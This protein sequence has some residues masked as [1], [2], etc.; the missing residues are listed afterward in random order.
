[1][2]TLILDG[3]A[4]RDAR[5]TE[6][7]ARIQALIKPPILA[8]V[9]VG[10]REDTNAYIKA[11]ITFGEKLGVVVK[12]IKLDEK[13]SQHELVAKVRECNEDENIKG[14]IIQLPLPIAIDQDAAIEAILPAKDV[15][16][17]TAFNVKQWLEGREE[18][19]L[20]A[21]TRGVKELLEHYKIELFGKHAV[22][23]GRSMLVGKPLA[24][25]CLNENA[26]V[27]VCHS[28]TA[29]LVSQTKTAD[30][31]IVAAGKPRL[32]GAGHVQKGTTVIDV[33]INTVIGEKLEDE[34][35]EKKLVGDVDFEAVKDIVSAI[36]PVPGGVGPMTVL[37]LFENL[38]DLCV[39][40]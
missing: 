26:F 3:K 4:V 28:K 19:V 31:L 21:T 6:L 39:K 5:F 24:A 17:L 35:P 16:G 15:D 32:I 1:M 9:Q 33:G 37:A 25:L 22:I 2:S 34:I 7:K 20:P 10:D 27:T 30:V 29:D 13:I 11:K 14:I 23:V 8:I 18:A 38:A 12:H 40:G 36:T